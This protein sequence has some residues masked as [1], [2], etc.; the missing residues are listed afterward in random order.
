LWHE[1]AHIETALINNKPYK[2]PKKSS[3]QAAAIISLSRFEHPDDQSFDAPEIWLRL[4]KKYHI[5][6]ILQS[7]KRD[8]LLDLLEDYGNRIANE[9]HASM[10][11]PKR[12]SH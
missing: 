6:F 7:K 4:L 12:S 2:L 3:H 8:R 5:G 10:E 9:F 1:W 11:A